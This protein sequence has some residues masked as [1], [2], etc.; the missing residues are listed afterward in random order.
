MSSALAQHVKAARRLPPPA[1][2][3]AIR[4]EAGV[5][6]QQVADELGVNRVSVARWELG[7]RVPRGELRLAYIGLLDELREDARSLSEDALFAA[8]HEYRR[9]SEDQAR[10]IISAYLAAVRKGVA[11]GV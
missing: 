10:G 5:S 6:Q 8:L 1:I 3:R 11:D 9:C 2:A 7:E 4:D